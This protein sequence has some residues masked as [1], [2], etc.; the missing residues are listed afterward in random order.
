[1]P[2]V[3]LNV[4][5]DCSPQKSSL[6]V[7]QTKPAQVPENTPIFESYVVPV[8]VLKVLG[9]PLPTKVYHIPGAVLRVVTHVGT[10]SVVAPTV[11]PDTDPPHG[12]G[13][14]PLQR[15]LG[16]DGGGQLVHCTVVVRQLDC[17]PHELLVLQCA[18]RVPVNVLANV[19][20]V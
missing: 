3:A 2:S 13:R 5:D 8:Q 4:T 16:I 7:T 10:A 1:M 15:S 6:P 12:S 17:V 19:R 14:A 11:V 18:K 20:G 9:A